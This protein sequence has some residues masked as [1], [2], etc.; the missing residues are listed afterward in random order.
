MTAIAL[1]GR[2]FGAAVLAALVTGLSFGAIPAWEA[3]RASVTGLL[4]DGGTTS[5]GRRRWQSVL[6]AT[7]VGCVAVLLVLSTLF[8]GSFLRVASTDLGLEKSNLLAAS[9]VTDYVGT[10][11]D[12]KAR[13]A[14]LPGVTGVAAATYSSLPL[15]SSAFGGAWGA[16]TLRLADGGSSAT[17]KAE[18]YRVSS[19]YFT[20]AG[21]PFSH[22]AT[23]AM[24][25]SS[26]RRPI[27]I[28]DAVARDLFGDTSPLGRIVQGTE[29][30][31]VFTVVGVVRP[32]LT[33]G[34][35]G[36]TQPAAYTAIAPN[37]R[38]SWV[39]FFV[40][41]VGAAAPMVR[42]VEAELATLSKSNDS[43]GSG[44]RVVDDAYR[45]LTS[46]RRFTGV[47]MGLFA[48]VQMLIGVTGI[49]AVDGVSRGPTDT[50]VRRPDC[51]WSDG[52]RH[53]ACCPRSCGD[54]CSG[55][56][57]NWIARGLVDLE[58][59]RCA[60]LSGSAVGRL[61]L[62]GGICAAPQRRR[63]CRRDTRQAGRPA[64]SG[65]HPA[66]LMSPGFPLTP[67]WHAICPQPAWRSEPDDR[68]A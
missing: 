58:R 6:L 56:A 47:L 11:D 30:T 21:I 43:A 4:K 34:P 65:C 7:Q 36:K 23:W 13:L 54:A 41:T 8:V 12:V 52:H 55:R 22:G 14:R 60:V 64:R 3:S 10:V 51:A 32:V 26:D 68:S 17:V 9:T 66:R 49:Y 33:R 1:D 53:S 38:P 16:S 45:Q 24:P 20:V 42:T 59:F 57:C 61:G 15:V 63:D 18:I 48:L 25:P 40:R 27:V 37:A 39:S 31:G 67:S 19:D 50:G 5:T 62:S 29:L 46:T 28:D 44:V 35:E 2:V